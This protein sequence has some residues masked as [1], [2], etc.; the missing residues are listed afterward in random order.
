MNKRILELLAP[1]K[2]LEYGLEAIRCGAD[3]VYIGAP[4]FGARS[5][6]TNTI[7][8]IASLVKEAHRFGV[9]VFVTL[10]TILFEEEL[11]DAKVLA[12]ELCEIDVDALIVQDMAYCTFNLPIPLHAST[13]AAA[14]TAEKVAFF[15]KIGFERV[16]L[17]RASSL[18]EIA[19]I[20]KHTDVELEAFVHGAICVSQSGQCYLGHALS[21]RSGN[22][23]VCSQPCR[24]RYNLVDES[25]NILLRDK[26]LLS[27]LD[28]NLSGSLKEMAKAGITS[29]KIEGRLKDISYLKNTILH[30]R[31]QLDELI[32]TDN[33][34]VRASWGVTKNSIETQLS[35]CFSRGATS[36]YLHSL[37]RGVSSFDTAKA[38]GEYI[39]EV[40]A[41]KG[42]LFTIKNPSA[43]L[44]NGDG[45]C[46]IDKNGLFR[47]TNI[48][49]ADGEAIEPNKMEGIEK[50]VFI[51]RNYD[52]RYTNT[53]LREKVERKI[54][55]EIS[56]SFSEREIR[57][58]TSTTTGAKAAI[59]VKNTFEEAK[60]R[61]AAHGNIERSLS[62]SGDTIF[63]IQGININGTLSFIPTSEINAIRR[64]LLEKLTADQG[65]VYQKGAFNLITPTRMGIDSISYKGNVTNS[66]ARAFYTECGVKEI[67]EGVELRDSLEGVELMRTKYCILREMGAC[68]KKTTKNDNLY[69]ENGGRRLALSFDC[70]NCEMVLLWD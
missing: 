48:N 1:A 57:F 43:D 62:K 7:E 59:T 20:H 50:G 52:H 23:G 30:Y 14:L 26:H 44:N 61:D 15:K 32:A 60:N 68:R 40:T 55:T 49:I 31:K 25:G 56:V 22:R 64:E 6:A 28:M 54:E 9:K 66:A 10:N 19:E 51:Y 13:Q 42:Y 69:L 29:F 58:Q 37:Q 38:I 16:V 24:S 5:N 63:D 36:Y 70:K 53:L 47:G 8:D 41:V 45:I 17:E 34:F 18:D 4:Q 27:L 65:K 21:G 67:E 35:K 39:G 33:T 46:F 12:L 2:N 11:A 3:A